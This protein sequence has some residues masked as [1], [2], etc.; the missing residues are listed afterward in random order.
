MRAFRVAVGGC[1]SLKPMTGPEILQ[2]PLA[3]VKDEQS[4]REQV[5]LKLGQPTGSFESDRILTFRRAADAQTRQVTGGQV[6]R[7]QT[8]GVSYPGGSHCL[9]LVFD[10]SGRLVRH[11]LVPIR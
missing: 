6:V 11:S 2:D 3:F 9:V 1:A 10:P 5:L 4:T 7:S 8:T